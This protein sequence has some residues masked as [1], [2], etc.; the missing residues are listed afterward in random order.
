MQIR[1]GVIAVLLEPER[2]SVA[3]ALKNCRGRT[4]SSQAVSRQARD[5]AS[6]RHVAHYFSV[7][8]LVMWANVTWVC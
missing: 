6:I 4:K 7:I 5:S 8:T 3:L 2:P 1:F